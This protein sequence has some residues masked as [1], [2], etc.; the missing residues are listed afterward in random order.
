MKLEELFSTFLFHVIT[1]LVVMHALQSDMRRGSCSL[2]F[3]RS[4]SNLLF[5]VLCTAL[6][7]STLK[8]YL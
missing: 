3:D 5:Y 1:F 7:R 8:M 2:S 6:G 4:R